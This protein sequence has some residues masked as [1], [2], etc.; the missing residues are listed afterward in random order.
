[1]IVHYIFQIIDNHLNLQM[2]LEI[3]PTCFWIIINIEVKEKKE[4]PE[5]III[6]I[7]KAWKILV[8]FNHIIL[9]FKNSNKNIIQQKIFVIIIE[10]QQIKNS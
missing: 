3:L 4:Q 9:K 6:K 7:N 8:N 2:E 5:S 10:K 1:M